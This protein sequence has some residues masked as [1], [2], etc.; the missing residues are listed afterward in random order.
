MARKWLLSL[1]LLVC[2]VFGARAEDDSWIVSDATGQPQIQLYFF[3]SLTCPHCTA[4]HPHV[5]AIPEQRPWV[6]VDRKSVV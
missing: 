3:W 5:V 6:R 2:A 1:L 4:A